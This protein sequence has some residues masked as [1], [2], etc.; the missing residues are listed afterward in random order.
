ML[1]VQTMG[2]SFGG[3]LCEFL[4]IALK[5]QLDLSCNSLGRGLIKL[6]QKSSVVLDYRASK[7]V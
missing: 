5:L 7:M 4:L 6:D 1:D 3:V 2:C